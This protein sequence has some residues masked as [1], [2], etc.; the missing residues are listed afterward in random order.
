MYYNTANKHTMEIL[1]HNLPLVIMSPSF[2]DTF[3]LILL[4]LFNKKVKKKNLCDYSFISSQLS[5]TSSPVWFIFPVGLKKT[6][7]FGQTPFESQ[8]SLQTLMFSHST[9]KLTYDV[10]HLGYWSQFWCWVIIY[11]QKCISERSPLGPGIHTPAVEILGR[12]PAWSIT[13]CCSAVISSARISFLSEPHIM[14][15]A[16]RFM[17]SLTTLLLD[18]IGFICLFRPG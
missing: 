6:N 3:G 17:G 9:P 15:W 11:C 2:L 7:L 12:T 18:L 16:V 13:H 5:G 4:V 1:A 14:N 8:L 10:M